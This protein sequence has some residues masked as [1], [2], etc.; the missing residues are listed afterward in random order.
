MSAM[1]TTVLIV[2]DHECFRRSA[3]KLLEA[4]GFEVVGEAGD[5]VSA[6]ELWAALEPDL[7]LLDLNLPRMNG[8]AVLTEIKR[9][10]ALRQIPVMILTTST[11]SQDVLR[12]YDLHAN[13]YL[14]KP[15]DQDQLTELARKIEGFW[16]GTAVMRAG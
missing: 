14:T 5:A 10:A 7:I 1:G 9:D 16:M 3:R 2:D 13:C 8:W 4:E 6:Q 11:S 15:G 12:A